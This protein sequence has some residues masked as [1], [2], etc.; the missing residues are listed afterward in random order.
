MGWVLIRREGLGHR[1]PRGER[2]E[3]RARRRRP[4]G[5]PC[6]G[7]HGAASRT[8]DFLLRVLCVCLRLSSRVDGVGGARSQEP[9]TPATASYWQPEHLPPRCYP[10][11]LGRRR[12]VAELF[13]SAREPLAKR[14]LVGQLERRPRRP[15]SECARVDVSGGAPRPWA[16]ASSAPRRWRSACARPSCSTRR[17]AP[18]PAAPA[19][20]GHR[21][22]NG[23]GLPSARDGRRETSLRAK[24]K[25]RTRAAT[26]IAL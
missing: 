19:R 12:A 17:A 4:R 15:K 26:K 20:G 25:R 23:V 18:S 3:L 22:E 16:R 10:R 13:Q 6:R 24:G 21:A 5:C 9:A 11:L 1:A 14:R 7:R 8:S 2:G